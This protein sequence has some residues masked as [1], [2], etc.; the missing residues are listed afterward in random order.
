MELSLPARRA[1]MPCGSSIEYGMLKERE[2]PTASRTSASK[3]IVS[4]V[5]GML[6]ELLSILW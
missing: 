2:C 5:D 6:D 1:A 3:I 4:S